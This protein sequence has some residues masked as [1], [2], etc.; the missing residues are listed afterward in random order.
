[1]FIQANGLSHFVEKLGSGPPVILSHCLG[2]DAKMWN[3]QWA[4]LAQ[5]HSVIRYDLR[6]H[7]RS[8]SP[9]GPYLLEDLAADLIGICSALS[10]DAPHFVGLSLGGMVGQVAALQAPGLFRSLVLADTACQNT[11]DRLKNWHERIEHVQSD[12]LDAVAESTLGR[13]LTDTYRASHTQRVK[14]LESTFRA[15][16][17]QGYVACV[18][19]ILGL[20]TL[21]R[22]P[23][24][25]ARTLLICGDS[26]LS[27]PPAT[28]E[29]MHRLIPNSRL[30][31]IHDAAHLSSVNQPQLFTAALRQFWND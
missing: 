20:A 5:D 10:L 11:P 9:T 16:S 6:G 3:E 26:D 22:L 29:E 18:H 27:T 21:Q 30:V 28:H 19:A 12:G 14:E 8:D 15:T 4:E 25:D 31:K 24:I 13:W 17:A 23:E 1:M 2:C 7:G